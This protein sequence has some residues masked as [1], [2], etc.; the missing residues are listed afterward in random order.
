MS[1]ARSVWGRRLRAGAAGGYYATHP[2][3]AD[4]MK[5]LKKAVAKYQRRNVSKVRTARFLDA[6]APLRSDGLAFRSASR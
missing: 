4:R 1:R 5:K 6:T 3:A 2:K